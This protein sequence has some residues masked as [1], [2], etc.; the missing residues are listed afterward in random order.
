M[1]LWKKILI[2][3]SVIVGLFIIVLTA[4]YFYIKNLDFDT[5]PAGNYILTKI[6][7]EENGQAVIV[8]EFTDKSYYITIEENNEVTSFSGN[9]GIVEKDAGYFSILIG[10]EF[11][12]YNNDEEGSLAY[13]GTYKNGTIRIEET[14]QEGTFLYYYVQEIVV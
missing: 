5:A 7:K 8:E 3:L 1:A 2:W 10:D 11:L 14:T 13:S 4:I 9:K 12:L 6:S